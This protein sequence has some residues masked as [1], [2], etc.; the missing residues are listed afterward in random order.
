MG[1]GRGRTFRNLC[2]SLIRGVIINIDTNCAGILRL[3][4]IN[5]H[6]SGR[7][8]L[9]RFT[10][11]CARP[12]F[13]R[14]P[15]RVGIRAGSREGRGP[16]LA[17]R[18]YSGRLLKL[19]YTGVHSFHGPRPCGNGNVLF[20]NRIVHEGSNGDTSTGWFW[21]FAV[22]AAGGMREQ[23]GVG[24]HVHGGIGKA[25]RHPHLDMF[26][27]GGRVCT[28]IVGSLANA[29]LTSTSSLNLRGVPGRRRTA[30]INRLVTRGTGTTNIRSM[31]FSHGN[32]LCRNHMGRLTSNTHGN[33]LGFW[34]VVTVSG[35]G[36]GGRRMLGSHLITVGHMAGIAGN[37]H[38]FAFTTVIIMNS[39]GNIVNCNLNGT[40]RIATTVT[41]NARTTGGGLIGIPML[42]N[43]IPRRIRATFNNTGILVGPTTTN[44]NLGTNNTV[45]T[46]LRDMNVGSIVTGSGNSSGTRGLMGTAV[47]T[48]TRVHSTC[49]MTNRHNVDVSGMFG[50]W[51]KFVRCNG[52]WDRT[53]W[54][55]SQYSD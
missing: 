50:N 40:N 30:G 38:A 6:I 24:F 42:G 35:M 26:H 44:A 1:I 19:I 14:L 31:I 41:G 49:A 20:G 46:I 37:N 55:W 11:N 29:A 54:R 33:N 28:R 16:V 48:L 10:L 3:M 34:A 7:N 17:L 5:C 15:G 21:L 47:T 36:M 32:C 53:S 27:S 22:V 25:T 13:V 12:V 52:G 51:L 43:A 2:H 18:S 4:N 9:V 39:N 45:H 23:V 8:G